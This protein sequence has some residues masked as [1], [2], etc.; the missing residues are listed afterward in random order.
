MSCIENL[1]IALTSLAPCTAFTFRDYGNVSNVT[2]NY[3]CAFNRGT[4]WKYS[5]VNIPF[6]KWSRCANMYKVT[7]QYNIVFHVSGKFE[8]L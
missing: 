2:I 7:L 6:F 8:N 5:N 1:T 3:L 4:I